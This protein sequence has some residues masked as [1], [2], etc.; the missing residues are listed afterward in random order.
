MGGRRSRDANAFRAGRVEEE[1][2]DELIEFL[3]IRIGQGG[4]LVGRRCGGSN[5]DQG[6]YCQTR[7][8]VARMVQFQKWTALH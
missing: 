1:V 4:R 8:D 6:Q 2:A 5:Q 3:L 7:N